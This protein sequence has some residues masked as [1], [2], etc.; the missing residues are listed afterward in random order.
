MKKLQALLRSSTGATSIEYAAV[1]SL[2]SIVAI[3]AIS[4]IGASVTTL[5]GMVPSF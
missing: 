2:V 4:S 1:A 5:F 3:T